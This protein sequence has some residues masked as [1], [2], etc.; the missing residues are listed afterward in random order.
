MTCDGCGAVA[1]PGARFCA[2]CGSRLAEAACA[3]CGAATDPRDR[4]CAACGAP[5]ADTAETSPAAP[6]D[7][8][9]R[10]PGGPD[11]ARKQVTVLF[12]D[13]VGSTRTAE[14][15]G[16]EQMHVLLARFFEIALAEVHRY[17]GTIDKFLGDGF[18][19]LFGV[20]VAHEDHA[21]RAVLAAL[22]VRRRLADAALG[23]DPDGRPLRTRM[24]LN[25][26]P[27]VV[28]AVGD[29]IADDFTAIGDTINVAARLEALARPG[30][31]V[32]SGAT[33]G[34]VSGYVRTEPLGELA[35]EGR[36]TPVVGHR[37]VGAGS[38]RSRVEGRTAGRF[39]GRDRQ[40]WAL[41]EL[42]AEARAGRG[43]VVGIVGEPGMGKTRLV[44]E[45][46]RGLSEDR[47][48]IIEGRCLSY[49]AAIPWAPVVDIVRADCRIA[50]ADGPGEAAAKVRRSLA[51][52]GIGDP[53]AAH[54][55][56]HML[57]LMEGT[58]ALAHLSPEAIR[59]RTMATLLQMSLAGSRRRTLVLVVE[60]LHWIDRVSEEFLATLVDDMQGAAIMLLCTYRPGYAAPWIQRSYATQ[61]SLPRLGPSDALAVVGGVLETGAAATHFE[62]LVARADGNPFFLEE[63]ARS[64][65]DDDA[66]APT[67]AAVPS[68]IQ[69]VL[70]ARV[71]R[72]GDEPRRVL[73]TASVLGREFPVRLLRAVWDGSAPLEPQLEELVRLEFIHEV[74][75][76]DETRYV[77][78]HALTQDVAY[79][80]L[81]SGRRAALHQRAGEALE[82]IHAG[83]LDPVL[84]RLAHHYSRTPRSDK[85]V[86]YLD[87]FAL[88]AVRTY[89]HAE[90]T[91]ALREA[92]VHLERLE[93]PDR[94]RRTVDLVMRLVNS[95][96]FL[97]RFGESLDLLL[98]Q[99]ERVEQIGDASVSGP[100]HMWLGHTYTHAGDS[101]GAAHAVATAMA[102]ATRADDPATLGKSHYVLSREGFWRGELA[103]GAEHG[104]RAVAALRRTDE[105]WWLAHSHCWTAINLC[106][107]GRFE[108]ALAEVGDAQRIGAEHADPRIHSYSLWNRCWFLAT[109]GDWEE[110][111]PAGT[112]S[113][114]TSPDSLNSSYSM[115][116][117][118]FAYREKG[119][120]D[121]AARHLGRSIELLTEFRYSRLVAWF[122]GWLAEAL[123]WNG[124]ID[125]ALATADQAVRIAREL[126]YPWGIALARR[127]LGRI[128]LAR[129]AMTEAEDHLGASLS[130]L[131]G[132][133]A[134]FDAA[135]VLL[136]L[137]ESAA[138]RSDPSR[139]AVRLHEALG[140]FRQLDAPRYAEHALAL[141]TRLGIPPSA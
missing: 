36:R 18:M 132:M 38:R 72:L 128:A 79:D 91:T 90:A 108:E 49:G 68:T 85:A 26:G 129:G 96:Y 84:D 116:W 123:L 63:L 104:R 66:T 13:I 107:L 87:R 69:D 15:V 111:I 61:I 2:Q 112:E 24:G 100:F 8:D 89:A 44:R 37:V 109:R 58:D 25:T 83:H 21:R 7:E 60:D 56:L 77:F 93:A 10:E 99:R 126:R 139:A 92:L 136:S 62:E 94:D 76:S 5:L 19:A 105:W 9:G 95:L 67:D 31:I 117:L 39:V 12:C 97:G 1:T 33:A 106:N 102:E 4:F 20:P 86:E 52:L 53:D 55:V 59:A 133:G 130:A 17:G 70:A 34:I 40:L 27:V 114:Q 137:A 35:I 41:H 134:R 73:Q 54:A 82:S 75:D 124:R 29:G 138:G 78:N 121:E 45:F 122:K 88:R 71:D 65:R 113:L 46:R 141:A 131:D 120:L 51:R 98:H 135:C 11:G 32:I 119:D 28:A 140:R 64:W 115:G 23:P 127:A 103:D 48:T 101:D 50:D 14:H 6:A 57:G 47:P 3:R 80:G 16:A 43:Q 81:L 110:A 74:V 125:D 118:G 30:D 42:L 22:G